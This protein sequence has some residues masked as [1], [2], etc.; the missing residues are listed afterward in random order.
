[1]IHRKREIPWIRIVQF[2]K[3]ITRRAE[4]AFFALPLG[5]PDSE[6][7]SSLTG[8]RPASLSGDW[9]IPQKTIV[10]QPLARAIRNGDIGELFLGCPC[11]LK[12]GRDQGNRAIL[13]WQPIIYRE[14][15]VELDSEDNFKIVPEKSNWDISRPVFEFMEKKGVQPAKPLDKLLPELI[16]IAHFRSKKE[17]RDLTDCLIEEIGRAIPELGYELNKEIPRG[18]VKSTPSPWVLFAPHTSNPVYTQNLMRDYEKLEKQMESNPEHIGGLRLLED[19]PAVK[20]NFFGWNEIP[21]DDGARF[22]E[23]LRKNYGIAWLRAAKIEKIDDGMTIKIYTENH[24]L[25]LSLNNEKTKVILTVDD[26]RTD[27]LIV[28]KEGDKLN[29]YGNVDMLS[30]VPLNESQREAVIGILKSKPVTVISGPPGC[31]KSQVVF[32]LLLNAWAKGTSVLFA[33]T[34]NQAV[35][36]V[37]KKLEPF[38]YDFPIAIRAGNKRENNIEDAFRRNLNALA[39]CTRPDVTD[40]RSATAR[41]LKGLS[42]KKKYLQDLLESQIPQRVYQSYRSALKAYGQYQATVQELNEA[43]ELH[44]KE[45][46]KLGYDIGPD[47]F[48]AKVTQPLRAWLEKIKE[49]RR[50]IEQDSQD[51]SNLLKSSAGFADARNIAVQQGGLDPD[52][53]TNWN[54]LI[55]GPAPELIETWFNNYKSLLSQPLER[56]LAPYDWQEIFE[57]WKGESDASNWSQNGRQLVKDI[58]HTCSE[59]SSKIYELAEVKNR[60]DEQ[61]SIIMESGI[62]IDIQI[63]PILLSEWLAVYAVELTLPKGKF[64]WFPLSERSKLI[65]KLHSTEVQIRPAYPLSIWQKVGEINKTGRKALSEIIESSRRWIA[66]RNLWNEKK[67]M[68]EEIENCFGALRKRAIEFHIDRVPNGTDLTA[69][70]KLADITEDEVNIADRAA[71]AWSK[72]AIAE[73]TRE[74]LQE[75][76]IEFQS[77]ASGVP[78]KEAWMKGPGYNFAQ[79]VKALGVNPTQAD[80]ANAKT[81]IYNESMVIL[82]RAWREARA[83]EIEHRAH[84]DAAKGIPSERSRVADWW[85]EKTPL[86]SVRRANYNML[87]DSDDELWKHLKDCED[88]DAKWKSYT[89]E[90]LPDGEKRCN[91]ELTW[92]INHLKEA[93][94]AIPDDSNKIQISQ[95]VKPLVDGQEKSWQI[96]DKLFESLN[97]DRIKDEIEVIDARL[98]EIYFDIAKDNWLKNRAE[99]IE[100]QKALEAL[101]YHYIRNHGVIEDSSYDIFAKALGAVSI[102]ITTAQ[103]SQ[104][105]PLQ[106]EI[107][108]ILVIDEATQCTLTNILPMI[109]RAKRIAV[110]GDPEQLPAIPAIGYEAEKTLAEKFNI[111][112]W[113]ELL[114]HVGNDVYKTAVR[115]LPRRRADV[116]SLVEHYRSH[117]LIIGFANQYVYQKRLRIRYDPTKRKEVPFG[118]GIHSQQ[119]NGYCLRGP[120]DE[121]WI[122]PAEKDAVC[123]LVKQLRAFEGFGAFTIGVV[124]P[125]KAQSDAILEQLDKMGLMSG[126]TVGTAHKFQGD[127]RD[128]MIFSPVVS[129]GITEGAARWVENPHNLINVAVTRAKEALFV[130]GDLKLCGQ[131]EGILGKLVK[132]AETISKL[133]K[134]SPY[135]LELFSRMVI[136]GWDPQVHVQVGDH[137]V[138][139]V[140]KNHGVKVAIEVD[141]EVIIKQDGDIIETHANGSLKDPSIDAALMGQ[142]YKVLHIKTRSIH[143]TPSVVIHDIAEALELDWVDI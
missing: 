76:A 113:L 58:R 67:T 93:V 13:Y 119:V 63:D 31:G 29:I 39:A 22:I 59:I 3:E 101:L 35:D 116:I 5:E 128:V 112:E 1:M 95:K 14:V 61:Y 44:V 56:Y 71:V 82:L 51:R 25:S 123:E 66:I 136:H 124:T 26:G 134:T 57:D 99:D 46:K 132:Y 83:A 17:D 43:H 12:W 16:E 33:S 15:R 94:D 107:F 87:P 109:Y 64:D 104:S 88:R 77:T 55:S 97:P 62:P 41:E 110:I 75:I 92:A 65:R 117:P 36:V 10:S 32:S 69:W 118:A 4:E 73:K 130:V 89:E 108:D 68:Q 48:T 137:E 23:F 140:L 141:G 7:W 72:K 20:E 74:R 111:T 24:F 21:G 120:R 103:S 54:W 106:P 98:E 102:W 86:V 6:R 45:I 40:N 50:K 122:N 27:E 105:I 80:V 19:L 133:R 131:Q 52:S 60:Y 49:Y 47:D 127:E 139:F 11:W 85:N 18:R 78:L 96:D 84:T 142:G 115:C 28:K 114:G 9:T 70:L 38:E 143:E 79:S 135:E 53:A 81:E 2:H 90:T 125:F 42:S 37:R 91:E 8:F 34:N 129:K 126:V 138:D 30:I 100:T 121:S